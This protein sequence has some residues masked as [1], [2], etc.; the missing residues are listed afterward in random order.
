MTELEYHQFVDD[1]LHRLEDELDDHEADI[2]CEGADGMLTIEFANRSKIVINK[3]EP[4]LQLWVATKYNG[5]HFAY[6][7]GQWIDQRGAGEFWQFISQAVSKQ[8]E[9][10]ITLSPAQ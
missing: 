5:H 3:Q 9:W 4:L 2:E 6:T 7:D 8:A 10:D 1:I